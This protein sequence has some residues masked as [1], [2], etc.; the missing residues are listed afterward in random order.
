MEIHPPGTWLTAWVSTPVN[1][2]EPGTLAHCGSKHIRSL[3]SPVQAETKAPGAGI[4]RLFGCISPTPEIAASI[5][6][7]AVSPPDRRC[8]A[9]IPAEIRECTHRCPSCG[10]LQARPGR[11]YRGEQVGLQNLMAMEFDLMSLDRFVSRRF[12]MV[13][14]NGGVAMVPRAACLPVRGSP[15]AEMRQCRSI[16]VEDAEHDDAPPDCLP[17]PFVAAQ[18]RHIK[19][20]ACRRQLPARRAVRQAGGR[21]KR[22][23]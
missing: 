23:P 13:H 12:A 10:N 6:P 2:P 19:M 4:H 18:N 16:A 3:I 14:S 8:L 11:R 22:P 9:A 15:P 17:W 5:L 20:A 21:K 7:G 1:L